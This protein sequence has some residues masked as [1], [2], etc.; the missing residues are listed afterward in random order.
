MAAQ[1][2]MSGLPGS[3]PFLTATSVASAIMYSEMNYALPMPAT[4]ARKWGPW[5]DG[6]GTGFF[7]CLVSAGSAYQVVGRQHSSERAGVQ[8]WDVPL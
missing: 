5:A 8:P 3:S 1:W 7:P 4:V 2:M 6:A